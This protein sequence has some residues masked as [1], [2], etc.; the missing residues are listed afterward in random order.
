MVIGGVGEKQRHNKNQ[1]TRKRIK[2]KKR[3]DRESKENGYGVGN[4]GETAEGKNQY[5]KTCNLFKD[6]KRL[7]NN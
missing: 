3:K 6:C 2:N 4:K 1:E 5:H 7:E